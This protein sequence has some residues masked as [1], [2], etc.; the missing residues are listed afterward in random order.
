MSY[1]NAARSVERQLR[2]RDEIINWFDLAIFQKRELVETLSFSVDNLYILLR[3]GFIYIYTFILDNSALHI[4]FST[5]RRIVVMSSSRRSDSRSNP[6]C[7]SLL[8]LL[9]LLLFYPHKIYLLAVRAPK[10][11]FEP[12]SLIP[13]TASELR[14]S[15]RVVIIVYNLL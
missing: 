3:N 5:W 4:I 13:R 7:G 15:F 9:L 14:A 2:V 1:R 6:E 11:A 8:L 12:Y 10:T